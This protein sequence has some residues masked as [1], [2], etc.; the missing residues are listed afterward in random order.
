[1]MKTPLTVEYLEQQGYKHDSSLK[2]CLYKHYL[3]SP[4][5]R[6][7]IKDSTNLPYTEGYPDWNIHVDSEDMDSLASF[8]V[9]NIEDANTIL[10]VYN[11]KL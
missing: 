5:G 4:D 7:C 11:L 10:G 3:V 9:N 8:D 6:I 2:T 1:M